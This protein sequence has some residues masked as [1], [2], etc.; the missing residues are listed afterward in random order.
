MFCRKINE[1]HCSLL[2]LK[3][4]ARSKSFSFLPRPCDAC[5]SLAV[6]RPLPTHVDDT[7]NVKNNI[8]RLFVMHEM[9]QASRKERDLPLSSVLCN[10]S[11]W[12]FKGVIFHR[13][14]PTITPMSSAVIF[15]VENS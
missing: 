6:A 2:T 5:R 9:L 12:V 7:V 10:S 15:K 14:Q 3:K 8:Q 13:I 11:M 4:V 1:G